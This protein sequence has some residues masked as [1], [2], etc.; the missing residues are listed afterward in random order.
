MIFVRPFSRILLLLCLLTMLF[1][2]AVKA[3]SR[4]S[5][6]EAF[7]TYRCDYED[8]TNTARIFAV[9]TDTN[10]L[11]MPRDRY[12]VTVTTSATVEV[13]P[14]QRIGVST[15][16]RREPMRFIIVMDTTD[17]MPLAEL[18]TAIS[19]RF[20][21]QLDVNDQVAFL[22]V[23]SEVAPLTTFY[24]DKNRLINEHML[25]LEPG[26][27]DNQVYNGIQR[28]VEELGT[29]TG[30]RQ[31]VLILTDSQ[32]RTPA[33]QP[34]AAEI[35]T[36]ARN[37][38]IQLYPMG[39]FLYDE[40]NAEDLIAMAESSQGFAWIY[41]EA[42]SN[43]ATAG[44]AVGDRLEDLIETLNSETL[45]AVDMRGQVPDDNGQ[46]LFDVAIDLQNGFKL[47][48][49][50]ACPYKIATH[51]IAFAAGTPATTTTSESVEITVQVETDFDAEDTSIVFR[52][53]DEPRQN[54]DSPTFTFDAPTAEPGTY[55]ISAELRDR[56]ENILATTPTSITI[57]AQPSITLEMISGSPSDLTQP[58]VLQVNT[59]TSAALPNARFSIYRV[60]EPELSYPLGAGFAP[61]QSGRASLSVPNIKSEIERLFPGIQTGEVLEI[62]A[63]VPDPQTRGGLLAESDPLTIPFSSVATIS[64][65]D[66][67]GT[68]TAVATFI[69]TPAAGATPVPPVVPTPVSPP[70]STFLGVTVP[71]FLRQADPVVLTS[72]LISLILL[73]LNWITFFRVGRMRIRRMILNPDSTEMSPRLMALTVRRDSLKQT[74]VLTKRTVSL[75]RGNLN[76]INLGD[77][78]S[79]SRE[80]GVVMWRRGK[81]FYSNRK[82]RLKCRVDGRRYS[83][84][85]LKELEPVTEIEIGDARVFFHS[86]T[87][88]DVSEFTKTTL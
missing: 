23:D 58:M 84:F 70:N 78:T 15:I 67:A 31:A 14:P 34:S 47:T 28:A 6:Q 45:I 81:W 71:E 42:N 59:P 86:S 27:G 75:G 18:V 76:D 85:I 9:L 4:T 8:A 33:D 16:P 40:P 13:V 43:N 3:E 56:S 54:G 53:N 11:P 29:N 62:I 49:Q 21:P 66:L 50:V 1:S 79:I 24:I 5:S 22:R 46:V 37:A 64:V 48:D 74:V 35:G 61:F 25:A 2:A 57:T 10:G 87:Q 68:A 80:H 19:T 51:S 17:T 39:I 30:M 7:I 82:P 63:T 77:S 36:R 55:T 65:T 41:D 26:F 44:V 20:V 12:T 83:G 69:S 72:A 73:L 32:P 60:S 88:Q 52:V 38:K